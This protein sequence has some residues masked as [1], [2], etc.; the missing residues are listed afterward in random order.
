[1]SQLQLESDLNSSFFRCRN[2]LDDAVSLLM[3]FRQQ[4]KAY[5]WHWP[6]FLFWLCSATSKPFFAFSFSS[7][8]YAS[9]VAILPTIS[10]AGMLVA[11]GEAGLD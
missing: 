6:R 8:A 1:M 9:D 5:I 10:Y 3:E 4:L 11:G 7:Y 2:L